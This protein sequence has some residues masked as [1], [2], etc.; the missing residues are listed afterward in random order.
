MKYAEDYHYRAR[1]EW[2]RKM[3]G[4]E[5]VEK[6]YM[7]V[8]LTA[9]YHS[10]ISLEGSHIL[11][12]E[13]DYPWDWQAA[14][15]GT[16]EQKLQSKAARK[17][18]IYIFNTPRSSRLQAEEEIKC[19]L[20]RALIGQL[21]AKDTECIAK[22]E[23]T[24]G[25]IQKRAAGLGYGYVL[26][27]EN[28]NRH[29]LDSFWTPNAAWQSLW[30]LFACALKDFEQEIVVLLFGCDTEIYE[31]LHEAFSYLRAV[32]YRYLGWTP[33]I[34]LSVLRLPLKILVIGK[35]ALDHTAT[36]EALYI[37]VSVRINESSEMKGTYGHMKNMLT[38]DQLTIDYYRMR[39][40]T[41]FPRATRTQRPSGKVRNWH[42]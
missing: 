9:Q 5:K 7:W 2:Q 6:D 34:G 18:F 13:Y 4:I 41:L 42:K 30:G 26:A 1:N 38:Y 27:K 11:F 37:D 23:E 29:L 33:A 39:R 17:E 16:I 19:S 40:L 8:L 21:F 20:P 25:K 32:F 22:I 31:A 28:Q 10:W 15:G 12:I 24:Q 3:R 14:L 36:E 35:P